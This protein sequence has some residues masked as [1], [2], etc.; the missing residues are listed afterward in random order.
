MIRFEQKGS[1]AQTSARLNAAAKNISSIADKTLNSYC[2]EV[3]RVLVSKLKSGSF[4]FTPLLETYKA[5]KVMTYGDSP[6]LVARGEYVSEIRVFKDGRQIRVGFEE[7]KRDSRGMLFED[8]AVGNEFGSESVPPRPHW[9]P[10]MEDVK[11]T[12]PE[13]GRKVLSGLKFGGS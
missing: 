9:R 1:P 12:I 2:E 8:I 6:I 5:R 13:V 7:G 10:T 4:S 3:R 11:Q